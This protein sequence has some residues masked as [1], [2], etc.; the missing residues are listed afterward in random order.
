[1]RP[2]CGAFFIPVLQY[3]S[4]YSDWRIDAHECRA[5][6]SCSL[7]RIAGHLIAAPVHC[8]HGQRHR[9]GIDLMKVYKAAAFLCGAGRDHRSAM[10][11]PELP[12]TI[13]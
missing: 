4:A 5:I 10:I 13:R 7:Y 12:R 6:K 2:S 9:A 8:L 11:F 3:C 1:M